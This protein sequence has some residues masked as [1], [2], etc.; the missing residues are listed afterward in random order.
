VS[1]TEPVWF[2]SI[3]EFLFMLPEKL[4]S[5]YFYLFFYIFFVDYC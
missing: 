4:F 3:Y 5:F 2:I 1:E